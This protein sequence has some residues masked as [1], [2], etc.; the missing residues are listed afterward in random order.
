MRCKTRTVL[1]GIAT[2]LGLALSSTAIAE[3]PASPA[4]ISAWESQKAALQAQQQAAQ[5]ERAALYGQQQT[6]QAEIAR[7]DGILSGPLDM[8]QNPVGAAVVVGGKSVLQGANPVDNRT[9]DQRAM[10][11][12]WVAIQQRNA[13]RDLRDQKRAELARAQAR[14]AQLDGEIAARDNQIAQLD[15]T[16]TYYRNPAQGDLENERA[17]LKNLNT[18]KATQ[19]DG[20]QLGWD[21]DNTNKRIKE[22]EALQ[23]QLQQGGAPQSG[24]SS[25]QSQGSYNAPATGPQSQLPPGFDSPWGPV[26]AYP[27]TSGSQMPNYQNLQQG[28][29]PSEPGSSSDHKHKHSGSSG[30]CDC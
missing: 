9:L 24:A 29:Q 15:R 22:L 1:S 2:V 10:D 16:I 23:Q 17:R 18:Q 12:A 11:N 20:G 8:V 3:Q 4:Q 19:D 26:M 30:G 28:L 6:L 7:L 14:A 25:G 13:T 21:I 27:P 5:G